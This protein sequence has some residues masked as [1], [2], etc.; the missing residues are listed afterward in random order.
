MTYDIPMRNRALVTYVNPQSTG[1]NEVGDE[2]S[3]LVPILGA[4]APGI[5]LAKENAHP[6]SFC[7]HQFRRINSVILLSHY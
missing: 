6:V 5:G 2:I 7:D 1:H 4:Q 3:T